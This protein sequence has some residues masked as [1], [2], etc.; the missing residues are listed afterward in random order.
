[1]ILVVAVLKCLTHAVSHISEALS[2]LLL[3][4]YWWNIISAGEGRV[5]L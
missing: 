3:F 4:L 5:I 1:M 2:V